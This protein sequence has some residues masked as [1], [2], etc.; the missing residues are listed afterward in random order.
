[1]KDGC[2]ARVFWGDITKAASKMLGKRLSE[3]ENKMCLISPAC[4]CWT[5]VRVKARSGNSGLWIFQGSEVLLRHLQEGAQHCSAG[6]RVQED[7]GLDEL[8]T[9]WLDLITFRVFSN[10]NNSMILRC[11]Y[12]RHG[13]C[14][15]LSTA[16]RTDS[17]V[18]S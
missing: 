11:C 12:A 15:F 6:T 9:S 2:F 8:L 14:P 3:R 18:N 13:H 16:W 17:R 4:M 10:L 7:G 1:M 5:Q